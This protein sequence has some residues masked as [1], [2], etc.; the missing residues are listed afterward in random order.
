MKDE[1]V[2][3]YPLDLDKPCRVYFIGIGGSSMSGLAEFLHHYGFTVSGSDRDETKYTGKLRD[4]G[5]QI[6]IGQKAEQVP[7]DADLVVYTAA[8]HA[9]N[10][11]YARAEQLGLPLMNR[12]VLLGKI[13]QSHRRSAAVAGTHGKTTTSSMVVEILLRAG[14]DPSVS[15]GGILDSIGSNSRVG[16][17]DTFVAEACEFTNSFLEMYPTVEA[18]LNIEE[19]HLDFFKDIEDIRRSFRL[20]MEHVPADGTIV[21]NKDIDRRAL[22]TAFLRCRV[23]TFGEGGDIRAENLVYDELGRPSFELVLP[24]QEPVHVEL[25]VAGAH[26][27]SNALAAAGTAWAMGAAP[28]QVADGLN[29]YRGARRRFELKGERNGVRIYD[30]YGHHPTELRVTL[31]VAKLQP[32]RKIW[33]VFQPFTYSR[34][35][36]LFEDFAQVLTL[37]D[38]VVLTPIMGARE[39]DTLGVSSDQLAERVRELGTS[40]VSVPDFESA[41]EYL[42]KNCIDGDLLITMGCGNAY[43]IGEA[44]LSH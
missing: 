34:T 32:H 26:N 37:A 43:K 4:M 2:K 3:D 10:P 38:E 23:L 13:M 17:R 20:F 12:A 39:T 19:D 5:M 31:E 18:V 42:L 24:G 1:T 30:D 25:Q 27:A 36:L 21:I 11:E 41:E 14:M 16:S 22:L 35:K 7:E 29:A 6:H 15:I 9:D 8:V 44:L 33:C 40:V 28:Q